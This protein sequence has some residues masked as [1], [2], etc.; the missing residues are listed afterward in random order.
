MKTVLW[1]GT[2]A[3]PLHLGDSR[4]AAV[5]V[6][7]RAAPW[8]SVLSTVFFYFFPLP[9]MKLNTTASLALASGAGAGWG[10]GWRD[11]W[12]I[13]V[14][15]A[16]LLGPGR[17]RTLGGQA[18]REACVDGGRRQR[19][20]FQA[21]AA[22]TTRNNSQ[23]RLPAKS[24]ALLRGGKR[25]WKNRQAGSKTHDSEIYLWNGAVV[26]KQQAHDER[27]ARKEREKKKK[28]WTKTTGSSAAQP[29]IA[30][31]T[32]VRNAHRH[33]LFQAWLQR[34]G[35]QLKVNAAFILCCF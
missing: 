25:S 12:C 5:A 8:W 23:L 17:E 3:D 29:L 14:R 16:F 32:F 31:L 11:G 20:C 7:S 19:V 15:D 28:N 13:T 6:F 10:V 24:K 21:T 4:A 34:N 18:G 9:I 27:P 22:L 33:L 30:Y 26:H 35:V 1:S 2:Q